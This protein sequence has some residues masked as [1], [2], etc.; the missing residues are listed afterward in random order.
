MTAGDLIKDLIIST[1][2]GPVTI[3]D[4][5]MLA[6]AWLDRQEQE[7]PAEA[8]RDILERVVDYGAFRDGAELTPSLFTEMLGVYELAAWNGWS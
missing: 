2:V 1:P 4:P 5:M 3:P 6:G 7:N 8:D